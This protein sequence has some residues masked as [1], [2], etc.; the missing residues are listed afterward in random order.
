MGWPRPYDRNYY[1]YRTKQ[2]YKHQANTKKT[3]THTHKG[4]S[5]TNMNTDNIKTIKTAG[6]HMDMNI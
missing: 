1:G 6:R 2:K 4:T 3:A 5:I